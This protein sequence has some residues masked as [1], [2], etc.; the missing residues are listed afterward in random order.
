MKLILSRRNAIRLCSYLIALTAVLGIGT[1][2]NHYQAQSYRRRLEAT[3]ARSLQELSSY[4]TNIFNT[5]EKG[6]YAGTPAQLS[7]L[8]AKLWRE[9]GSA[10]TALSSLPIT[11]F[12]LTNTY[13]FLSQVGD[14]AMTVSR[15][16][17]AAQTL[18]DED[19]GNLS[20]L[21]GYSQKL[22]THISDLEARFAR[23]EI[24]IEQLMDPSV[25]QSP[26]TG[27]DGSGDSDLLGFE[28]MEDSFVGY[29]NLI[30]DGPFS[31]HMLERA[32]LLT[33]GQQPIT[34]QAAREKAAAITGLA[35][36]SLVYDGEEH[37]NMPCYGFSGESYSLAITREGG[38]LA[39][40]EDSRQIG[41]KQ[42]DSAKAIE[43]AREYLSFLGIESMEES[44]YETFGGV[45]TV[46]FAYTQDGVTCYT[47]LI[48]VGVALDNGQVVFVDARGYI[49]NHR[50]RQI[51]PPAISA[52][53]A[54]Q[55]VS[56]NL[57]AQASGLAIIPSSGLNEVLTYEF[58]CQNS[59][60]GQVLV[61]IN[62]LTGA[63][64][65][66]LLLIETEDG[67]LTV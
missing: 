35:A 12:D 29:P 33:Q 50:S 51:P 66:I 67:V 25:Q 38:Y 14:Y 22:G 31:D 58:R 56:K 11:E 6:I 17:M 15:E 57:T 20:S 49:T 2:A 10:K 61:Y 24:T 32:P 65:Q 41:E 63:E 44:Y 19:M 53:K 8:S 4:M 26:P 7:S 9:A 39:Y 59:Q 46:N 37:S 34:Q 30:Y 16:S 3:Y 27:E 1:V 54:Q 36:E 62:A 43:K 48:K 13:K 40:L 28:E 64:E 55:A 5:L 42:I 52:A 47:D 23:G 18:D 21:L 60:G 45:C